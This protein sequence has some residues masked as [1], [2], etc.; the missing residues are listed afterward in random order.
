MKD[1]LHQWPSFTQTTYKDQT[2]F[3]P[4]A[5]PSETKQLKTDG[6]QDR[7]LI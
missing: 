4:Y 7:C 6:L 5:A 3:D 1:W 2:V